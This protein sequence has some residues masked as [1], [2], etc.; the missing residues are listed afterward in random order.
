MTAIQDYLKVDD[1]I[2]SHVEEMRTRYKKLFTSPEDCDPMIIINTPAN[3]PTWEEI[4][5]DP[6]IM[7]KSELDRLRPHFAM[8]DDHVPT[9][10]VQFGT[11]QPASAYGCDIYIPPNSL[12]AAANH[13]LARIEDAYDLEVPDINA[14]WYGK[15]H[16]WTDIWLESLPEGIEIQ[17]PDIQSTFN[18]AH[19]VR[20][21][22]I[23]MDFYDNPDALDA[24][25]TNVTD[26][27][28][29]I[30]RV[31]KNRIS[32]DTEYFYDWGGLWKGTARISNCT[33]QLLPPE[34]Y[35]DHVKKHDTRFFREINGGRVHYCGNSREM[36]MSFMDIDN[37]CGCDFIAP[38][39]DAPLEICNDLPADKVPWLLTDG[40]DSEICQA[41]L[42]GT[43][44]KKRNFILNTSAPDIE[45]G[46]KLLN[47][48]REAFNK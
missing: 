30:T 21:N 39:E 14:G 20:G 8:M 37:V 48:L 12:P 40:R 17:H 23:F 1:A 31:L 26:F 35:A 3:M 42:N 5:S 10:R 43:F 9:V 18:T 25:L 33:M 6:I 28:I 4:L 13:V 41:I 36:A 34:L 29:K 27:M 32:D 19:L 47:E 15:L 44:P 11:A 24:L 16:E 45:S 46:K 38:Y 22:D 7:L 2:L